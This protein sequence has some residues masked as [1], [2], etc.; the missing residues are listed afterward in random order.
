[1]EE[2][3]NNNLKVLGSSPRYNSIHFAMQRMVRVHHRSHHNIFIYYLCYEKSI[4]IALYISDY[5]SDKVVKPTQ[6]YL[7][8]PNI[9]KIE[10]KTL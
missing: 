8:F 7:S 10:K 6:C 5:I 1:M 3:Q 4:N 2:R 9:W